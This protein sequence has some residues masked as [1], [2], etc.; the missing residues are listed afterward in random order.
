MAEDD[1]LLSV[2]CTG[3][4][5]PDLA[6]AILVGRSHAGLEFLK[7]IEDEGVTVGGPIEAL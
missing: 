7:S 2:G 4:A 3:L 1:L 6:I 5:Q